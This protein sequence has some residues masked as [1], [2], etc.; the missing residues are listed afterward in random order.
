MIQQQ[1]K[2]QVY[3]DSDVIVYPGAHEIFGLV[4]FEGLVCGRPVVVAD[5]SG[6]GEII[7]ARRLGLTV[8][9][10]NPTA[11]RASIEAALRGGPIVTDM[12]S[13]GRQFVLRELDWRRI[14]EQIEG[15]YETAATL[16]ESCGA[17]S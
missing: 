12:T 5:D 15:V 16:Q 4:P 7:G 13:R 9:F 11:L 17:W 10:G 3:V 14:A 2:V 6:C 8:P 1:D